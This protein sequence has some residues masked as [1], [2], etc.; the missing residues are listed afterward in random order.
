MELE[1]DVYMGFYLPKGNT[2]NKKLLG[3]S[4]YKDIIKTYLEHHRGLHN[5][6]Y[7]IEKTCISDS[8]LLLK[9]NDFIISKFHGY[10]IPEIDQ[11]IISCYSKQIEIDINNTINS[12]KRIT[13]LSMDVKKIPKSDTASMINTLN[14]LTK[15]SD[16][17]RI[18]DKMNI[19]NIHTEPFLFC[20]ID[21]YLSTIRS[22][23]DNRELD[24][25]YMYA[26]Y[27]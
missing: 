14:I 6:Q 16:N 25:M 18:I 2:Y 15:Y 22:F 3:I 23:K 10:Y 20:E 11:V 12:L 8:D 26:M 24:R 5:N 19:K 4:K 1:Q 27:E 17:P 9:Y 21:E 7:K 13:L